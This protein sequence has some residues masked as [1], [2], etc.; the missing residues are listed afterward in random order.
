MEISAVNE[1]V[2]ARIA[3]PKANEYFRTNGRAML[4]PTS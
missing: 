4:A 3:R 1:F 2:V